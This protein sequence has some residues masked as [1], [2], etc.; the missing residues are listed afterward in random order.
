VEGWFSNKLSRLKALAA[1][2]AAEEA[3]SKPRDAGLSAPFG[4]AK[5][6]SKDR[7]G[8]GGDGKK[9]VV[10]TVGNVPLE[11]IVDLADY[12]KR[13]SLESRPSLVSEIVM[14]SLPVA[15]VSRSGLPD[16]SWYMIP[17]PEICTKWSQSISK[18]CKIFQMVIKYI[19]IFQSKALQNLPQLEFENIPFGNPGPSTLS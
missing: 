14:D 19:N 1:E 7:P 6:R 2:A 10:V 12:H 17:K 9:R 13:K 4:G 11:N 5:H 16:F 18:A 15:A 8:G 3:R